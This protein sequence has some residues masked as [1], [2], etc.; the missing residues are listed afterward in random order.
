MNVAAD[1]IFTS[2]HTDDMFCIADEN[3]SIVFPPG[4]PDSFKSIVDLMQED[5]GSIYARQCHID[6]NRLFVKIYS[7]KKDDFNQLLIRFGNGVLTVAMAN[8]LHKRQ[9]YL[10]RLY[11]IL[12][13][14]REEYNLNPIIM[15]RCVNEQSTGWCKKFH[16]IE[17]ED[18]PT[19]YME[20]L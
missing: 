18:A 3:G 15:E 20:P 9:G 8:F 12:K 11:E 7:E 10:T 4:F 13:G 19:S 14:I 6:E 17:I 1:C 16:F 2:P 5:A